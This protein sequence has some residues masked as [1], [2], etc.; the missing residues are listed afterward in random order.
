MTTYNKATLKTFFETNDVPGGTDYANL[1]DSQ[2]NLVET[3]SQ[4]M[5]GSLQTT[6]LIA[7]RVSAGNGNFT[8]T[9]SITGQMSAGSVNISTINGPALNITAAT[10]AGDVNVGGEFI[11]G[12]INYTAAGTAQA[13]ATVVSA[14]NSFLTGAVD[15]S[16]TGYRLMANKTGL[17]Q[18]IYN[19]NTVSANLWPCTGGQI[20]VLAS[21]AAFGMAASTLYTV[22]HVRASGYA[23]K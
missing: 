9:L 4:S 8:G 3:A 23:V 11:R 1:I 21:N 5:A 18:F 19:Q 17:M 20:N 2:V 7:S 16:T 6:E 13:T 22:L 10:S 12:V 15:G 14:G